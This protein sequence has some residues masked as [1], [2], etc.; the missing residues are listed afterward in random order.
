MA[1]QLTPDDL[2]KP[3]FGN[4]NIQAQGALARLNA[5]Q[6]TSDT[7]ADPKTL[8]AIQAA[9]G[10][11]TGM[12]N[13]LIAGAYG[14]AKS[15]PEAI[16]T[17]QPPAPLGA[18]YAEEYL[19]NN[20]SY[21][22]DSKYGQEYM[23]DIGSAFDAAHLPPVVGDLTFAHNVGEVTAPF[24]QMAGDYLR[25][26]P[27]SIGLATKGLDNLEDFI[28]PE[29]KIQVKPVN[30][31]AIQKPKS[32]SESIQEKLTGTQ[33]T[34]NPEESQPKLINTKVNNESVGLLPE[35]I[36]QPV[37]IDMKKGDLTQ[38]NLLT[39]REE[40]ETAQSSI[41]S[42]EEK[43]IIREGAKAAGVPISE[44]E[45]K[46]R[47]HK[48]DNPSSGD[49]PW[50]PLQL[51]R[52]VPNP[53]KIGDYDV[54]YKTI[55]YSY[56][57]DPE[58]NLIKP[59]TPEYDA[60]TQTLAEKLKNEVKQIYDRFTGGDEAASSI[61]RQAGWY[62]EMRSRLRQEFGGMGDMF[63]DLLGATSPNTPVRENWKN[64]VDLLRKA[65]AGAFDELI[66]KWENWYENL[67]A[68]EQ[69]AQTFFDSKV[70]EGLSKKAVKESPEFQQIMSELK[71]A[72][73]F[74]EEL[75]P[76]KDTG[77]KYGFNGQN[78]VRALL[79][80]F[81]VV[82]NP[83]ADI[84]IGATAP[85]AITF[86]GNLIGFKDRATIDVWAARLLQRLANK[87]RV[88]SMAESGVSGAMLPDGTTTGQFGMG[89]DVFRKAV[90]M[91]RNDPEMSKL[92]VLKN[93]SDD[94][95][96]ALVWFKEKE[97]WTKK[98][99]TS[100]AGEGGSFE[101]EADL[102]GI[103]NQDEVNRLRK[104]IDTSVSVTKE[105]KDS[106]QQLINHVEDLRTLKKVAKDDLSQNDL[107]K[108]DEQIKSLNADRS[109]LTTI[110][111]KPTVEELRDI[112]RG[113]AQEL[114][115]MSR[116]LERFQAGISPQRPEF[117]PT[118][119][120]M[121][122]IGNDLKDAIHTDDNKASVMGSKV[123][124]TEGRYGDPE[125]SIDL[126]AVV[127]DGFNPNPLLKELVSKAQKY[128]QDSTFLSRVLRHDETPDPLRHRPGVEIYFKDSKAVDKLQPMLDELAKE[129]VNF[130]TVVVDGRRSSSA[131]QGAMPPA[132]GVRF[133][134]VPEFEQRYGMFD[135]S[136]LTDDEIAAKV[137]S[138][139]DEMDKLA[140]RVAK[141]IPGV[142]DAQQYWY[143]T[144]VLFKNQYQ[145]KL[146]DFENAIATPSGENTQVGARVWSGKPIRAG[147]EA[148]TNWSAE[149]SREEANVFNGNNER[150]Q[151]IEPNIDRVNMAHKDVLKRVPQL[152]EAA[153]KLAEGNLSLE[154][155]QD[156]VNKYKPIQP[157]QSAPA[158]ATKQQIIDALKKTNREKPGTPNKSE[159]FGVPSKTLK[160]G[161]P[162]GIRLDI[163]SYKDANTW[164]VTVHKAQTGKKVYAGAGPRIGYE[165]VAK[166]TDVQFMVH[167]QGALKIAQGAEKS[168]LAT[169]EGKWKP[170]TEKQAHVEAKDYLNDP[171]WSQ[172]GMDPER[173]SYFYDR[174]TG[175]PVTHAD[176]ILQIGPLVLAKNARNL[177][178]AGEFKYKKG[179][180]V[181]ITKNPD[182]MWM[183]IQNRKFKGN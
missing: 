125:R 90:D 75:L 20:P 112:K 118:N 11:A 76:V 103:K 52:I 179:G 182:S 47:K 4:P 104:M 7:V 175:E 181:H 111:N 71:E 183:D 23:G 1:D 99:W 108:I 34:A 8:G 13:P 178:K 19:Q 156:L 180:A 163:P 32:L 155:Y 72:R 149:A 167:P 81:R 148:A 28:K 38:H 24:K 68:L 60:H 144:E 164:V 93:I 139:A 169:M 137:E 150:S 27:P 115:K 62:K 152:T 53:K 36:D 168:T 129:G 29:D 9:L 63:A 64:A 128:N 127:R 49:E 138:Q 15:I 114:S 154:E 50:A 146:N 35:K 176:E 159:Y 92:D 116:P 74:P 46:V 170:T 160:E 69:K 102:A 153:Q 70:A 18:K 44:I 85:K 147:V 130:Y 37:T 21:Q 117:V 157:Y 73:Q 134:L 136:K 87:I 119:E 113:A 40:R 86:S 107:D 43:D 17:G 141:V 91:I 126:E 10:T 142:S 26:N 2:S 131:M 161:D 78:A 122:S 57:R 120:D 61:I 54:E 67:N 177:S 12:V 30:E 158:P 84:G 96:Q 121:A 6:R 14:I 145:E 143:D 174:K 31:P 106:A 173:H 89:Q 109:K 97:L 41:L 65:S 98:N 151:K 135:W 5:A 101:Q 83:N 45:A 79:D 25:V 59:N 165:P 33:A 55:P 42:Q 105:V 16:R 124:S 162:V 56:D 39:T 82:K 77:A 95:L 51:S 3:Y 140:A 132:V 123:L 88:P 94:D 133:Q 48:M 80:L 172:V 22:P 66:P 100:S 58:D 166:A 110:I 171:E